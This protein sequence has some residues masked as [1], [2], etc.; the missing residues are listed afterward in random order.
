MSI[1]DSRYNV[2]DL[3]LTVSNCP[4][5]NGDYEGLGVLADEFGVDDALIV[6]L[7]T[8]QLVIAD[9]LLRQ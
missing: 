8:G 9:L 2:Y 6:Q 3:T 4:G 5:A 7:D 1:I